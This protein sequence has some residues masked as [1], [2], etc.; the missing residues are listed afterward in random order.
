MR[1]S[2]LTLAQN[3][4]LDSE[5]ARS[6]SDFSSSS[7]YSA[8]TPRLVCSSSSDSSPYRAITPRLVSWSSALSRSS[9]SF[10]CLRSSSALIRSWFCRCSSS[11][12]DRGCTAATCSPTSRG[13]GRTPGGRRLVIR[14]TWPSASTWSMSRAAATI[15]SAGSSP[16]TDTVTSRSAR[17]MPNVMTAVRP[18]VTALR[19]TS[20]SAVA[21]LIWSCC[22]RARTAARPRPSWRAA[23]TPAVSLTSSRASSL[24]WPFMTSARG[25]RRRRGARPPRRAARPLSA[26]G[27]WSRARAGRRLPSGC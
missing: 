22:S 7:A 3:L 2:W 12:A 16:S 21:T 10:C 9:W 27:P 14:T 13:S 26:T 23:K 6:R 4:S 25:R 24:L 8:T 19:L 11:R 5:A 20:L 1:S 15:P 18:A 17:S